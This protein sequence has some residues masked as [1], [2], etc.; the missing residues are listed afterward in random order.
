MFTVRDLSGVLFTVRDLSDV[1]L[2]FT[3]RDLSDA[4]FTDSDVLD[5]RCNVHRS[6]IQF[7]DASTVVQLTL[8]LESPTKTPSP[9][10]ETQ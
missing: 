6:Q 9:A 4:M 5:V 8:P 3:V 10:A 7:T 2:M 1:M